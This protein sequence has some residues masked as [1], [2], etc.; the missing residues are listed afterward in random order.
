M[1]VLISWMWIYGMVTK[2]ITGSDSYSWWYRWPFPHNDTWFV[3]EALTLETKCWCH[4][5][6]MGSE[7]P[8]REGDHWSQ[9]SKSVSIFMTE[10]DSVFLHSAELS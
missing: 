2:K 1:Y 4:V 6:V 8:L 5:Y 10:A 7:R 9:I 3:N